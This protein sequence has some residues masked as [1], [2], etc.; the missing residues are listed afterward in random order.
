MRL[1]QI[2]SWARALLVVLLVPA[3]AI[4]QSAASRYGPLVTVERDHFRQGY[5]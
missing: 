2:G 4:A 1:P 5:D 3:S